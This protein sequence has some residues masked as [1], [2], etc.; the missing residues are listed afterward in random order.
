MPVFE[1]KGL[2]RSGKNVRG[3]IDAENVRIAKLKLKKKEIYASYLRN[4]QSTKKE[5]KS[6]PSILEKNVGV[7]DLGLMTRQ[8]ATLI[9]SNIP[10]VESL[11]AVADQ[12]DHPSLKEALSDIKNMVNSGSP[13]HKALAKYPKIFDKIFVSMC[14]AGEMSG[15]LD[16]ILIRLAEFKEAQNELNSKIKSAMLYPI[17]MTVVM[18]IVLAGLFVFVIPKIK[19]IFDDMDATLPWY[20]QIVIDISEMMMTYWHVIVIGFVSLFFVFKNWKSSPK[21]SAQWD[22]IKLKLP[23]A[24][25]ITRMVAVSRFTRTL[26]TLLTGGVPMLAAM[27]TVQNVVDNAVLGKAIGEARENISEGESIAKPLKESNEF[28]PI[29]IHMISIGE[30][31]GELENM[32]T[33]VSESYDF[34]VKNKIEGLTSILE[35]VMIV[36]MGAVIFIVVLAIMVP[37]MEMSSLV[38][39]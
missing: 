3:V 9:K 13:F 15:T 22:G 24:G 30:K 10:L 19:T 39:Q 33:Q 28:P 27:N 18:V 23:V 29:V 34:Q 35:P 14:E 1:Y 36:V 16:T 12:V 5:K 21:G 6:A 2:T 11:N 32:L 4:K 7:E 37:I 17:I 20:S 38:S 26:S 8:L 31:T 25:P